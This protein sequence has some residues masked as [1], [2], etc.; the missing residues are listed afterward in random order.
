MNRFD[1]RGPMPEWPRTRAGRTMAVATDI[2]QFEGWMDQCR[3]S[4]DDDGARQ[5]KI[6]CTRNIGPCSNR[7][8][9]DLIEISKVCGRS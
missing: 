8:G 1:A 3:E 4:M 6:Q 9:P 2:R 5:P 7:D